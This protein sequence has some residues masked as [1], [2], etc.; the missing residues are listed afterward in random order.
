M[1]AR[2][3]HLMFVVFAIQLIR[4]QDNLSETEQS[5]VKIVAV[6]LQAMAPLEGVIQIQG[7]ITNVRGCT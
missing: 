3:Y 1:N 4:N 7:D 2:Q 5:K 6:D